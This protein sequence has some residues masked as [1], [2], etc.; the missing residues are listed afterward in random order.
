MKAIVTNLK[1]AEKAMDLLDE[2]DSRMKI[3][4]E[5]RP[6]EGAY[7]KQINQFFKIESP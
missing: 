6:F 1:T 3:I 5:I 2:I 7:L 4:N